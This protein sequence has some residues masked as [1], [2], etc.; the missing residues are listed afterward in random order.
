[1]QIRQISKRN[2]E[3]TDKTG[4]NLNEYSGYVKKSN[5]KVK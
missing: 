1:M 4:G 5:F 3:A 2:T